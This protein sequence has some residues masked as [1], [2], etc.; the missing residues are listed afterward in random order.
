MSNR[1]LA[2]IVAHLGRVAYC[3]GFVAGLSSAQWA[4]LRYF[5]RA[6]RFSRTVSAFADF[7]ATTRGTASQTV[8]SLV[9][10]GYLKRT[11]S[12]RDGRSITL[13]LTDAGLAILAEDPFEA[14][15]GAVGHLPAEARIDLATTLDAM[16][17]EVARQRGKRPFGTCDACAYFAADRA[18]PAQECRCRCRLMEEPISAEE[19]AQVCVNYVPALGFVGDDAAVGAAE[20]PAQPRLRDD[21]PD[22][23]SY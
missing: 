7:H 22:D 12:R 16:M 1:A 20:R 5:F 14:L 9:S 15:V 11:R 18:E 6:N 2:E 19:M 4:A 3:D 23:R 10:R 17:K 21:R 13:D 8:K